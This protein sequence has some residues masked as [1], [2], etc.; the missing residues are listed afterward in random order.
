MR[1]ILLW[2]CPV[3]ASIQQLLLLSIFL[4]SIF[5]KSYTKLSLGCKDFPEMEQYE[6]YWNIFHA[7]SPLWPIV[8]DF[9]S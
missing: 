4:T 9:S 8:G 2:L 3:L 5:F 1:A 6:S 7:P